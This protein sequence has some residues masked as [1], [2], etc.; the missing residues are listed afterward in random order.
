MGL[1]AWNFYFTFRSLLEREE[2]QDLVE[3]ALIVALIALA[4]TA[5]MDSLANAI[6]SA[7]V[8]VTNQFTAGGHR[9][10]L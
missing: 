10:G 4:A 8:N 7:F 6:N 2:G 3:Y 5:G 1:F 9:F